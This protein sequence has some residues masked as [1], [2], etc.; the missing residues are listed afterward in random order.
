M[1]LNDKEDGLEDYVKYREKVIDIE[2]KFEPTAIES[3]EI[4]FDSISENSEK[5]SELTQK[6]NIKNFRVLKKIERLVNLVAPIAKEYEPEISHQVYQSLVLLS[7]CYYCTSD[8]A[9]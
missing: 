5:L 1:L 2:L 6:L 9:P 4:A 3:S 8:G 7:W